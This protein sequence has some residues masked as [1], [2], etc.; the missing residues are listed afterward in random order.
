MIRY[1]L[2]GEAHLSPLL[3]EGFLSVSSDSQ[4][5]RL[6]FTTPYL[7]ETALILV[8]PEQAKRW[9][10]KAAEWCQDALRVEQAAHYLGLA[11]E[12]TAAFRLWRLAAQER[13]FQGRKAEALEAY[14]E[15]LLVAPS[16]ALNRSLRQEVARRLL[17]GGQAL[18]ALNWLGTLE[19]QAS[20]ALRTQ[21][22]LQIQAQ[23]VT[24]YDVLSDLTRPGAN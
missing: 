16:P 6:A 24:Q 22:R 14:N 17:E 13:W 3:N 1:L 8:S 18:Q 7:R 5:E 10:L 4:G 9:W 15:A 2:G 19:D 12:G 21:A 23:K 11:G 20:E